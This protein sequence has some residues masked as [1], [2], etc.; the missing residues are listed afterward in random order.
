MPVDLFLAVAPTV[1][2]AVAAY[3]VGNWLPRFLPDTYSP[4]TGFLYSCV[5]GFGILG[6][7][8]FVV[9]Q[10]SLSRTT[11]G[12]VLAVGCTL[13][14]VRLLR[15]RPRLS[16]AAVAI[17]RGSVIPAAIVATVLAIT[18]AAALSEPVGDVGSDGIAYHFAG[19]KV[20]VRND[21]IRPLPDNAPTSYPATVEVVFAALIDIGDDRAP[22]FSAVLTFS[23][24]LATCATIGR[25]CGLD[26]TGAWWAVALV[27]TMPAVYVGA[28]SGFI[29]TTYAAFLLIAARLAFDAR[30]RRHF[31]ALGVFLGLLMATKYTGLTAVPLV[32]LLCAAWPAY[33]AGSGETARHLLAAAAVAIV[34]AAPVYVRN[35]LFFGSPLYPPPP[36]LATMLTPAY[37]SAQAVNDF[38]AYNALRGSGLGSGVW[39]FLYLP[40]NLTYHSA[41]FNG[42]GGIGLAP[43]ALGP[44]GLLAVRRNPFV[45]RLAGLALL[46]L[47]TWF[48]TM[49]EA[50]FLIALYAL[51]AVFAVLG[52]RAAASSIRP[53]GRFLCWA[54]ITWS[55]VYGLT[56]I[57]LERADDIRSALSPAYAHD[58]RQTNIPYV[59]S[60]DYLNRDST[61]EKL[62]LLDPLVPAYYFDQDYLKAFGQYG[63]HAIP[64][65]ATP[66][67]LL[68]RLSELRV[69]HVLDVQSVHSDFRVPRDFPGLQMVFERPRQRVY[70]V[71]D[72]PPPLNSGRRVPNATPA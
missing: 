26:T 55:V 70:R 22:W 14:I 58:R 52:W 38:Y 15:E 62:L 20:W 54:V 23:L 8:L 72:T 19:P 49:Q 66:A 13:A 17:T 57:G 47:V 56:M 4:T 7:T 32:M 65:A 5:G 39:S 45:Q 10:W 61:V 60:V 9:G 46:L 3:G 11:I 41:A 21:V 1:V 30:E 71:V 37:M 36:A 53:R 67:D 34:V 27:S 69:S 68:S 33:R 6:A 51:G 31:L 43:L 42:A 40:Y 16:R 2:V 50:R 63:E 28:H 25:R 18:A 12:I 48:A 64:G 24:F 59:E 29:D 35:W 44:M